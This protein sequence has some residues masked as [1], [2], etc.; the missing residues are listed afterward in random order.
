M[1]TG[2]RCGSAVQVSKTAAIQSAYG[3]RPSPVPGGGLSQV[4]CGSKKSTAGGSSAA[5]ARYEA[6][7]SAP[8]VDGAEQA[9]VDLPVLRAAKQADRADHAVIAAAPVGVSAVQVVGGAV[10]VK[11]DAYLDPLSQEELGRAPRPDASRWCG[12]AGQARHPARWP[13]AERGRS[14]RAGMRPP[15]AARR[16]AGRRAPGTARA[17]EHARRCVRR[18]SRRSSLAM[19][20]RAAAPTLIGVLVDVAVITRQVAATVHLQD[21][22]PETAEC[23][24]Y[25]PRRI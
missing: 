2:I 12:C 9:S 19:T 24:G 3:V 1:R 6:T 4:A 25:Q 14:R 23:C 17:D 7:G 18:S 10:T 13:R 21:E 8:Q 22:L 5:S 11:R 15:A 16:R 20:I